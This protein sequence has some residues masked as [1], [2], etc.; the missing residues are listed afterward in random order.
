VKSL[1]KPPNPGEVAAQTPQAPV[2]P[3]EALAQQPPVMVP[4]DAPF[5]EAVANLVALPANAQ[6][7]ALLPPGGGSGSG[8]GGIVFG[9]S[10]GGGGGSFGNSPPPETSPV[11]SPPPPAIS[12]VPE[13]GTWLMMLLGFGLIGYSL[14]RQSSVKRGQGRGAIGPQI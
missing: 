4:T 6:Q 11:N 5:Q 1:I 9:S 2:P 7:A 13:P 8:G 10:G 14:R 12:A 3:A